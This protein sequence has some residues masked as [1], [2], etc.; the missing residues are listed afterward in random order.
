MSAS[1][2]KLTS[3]PDLNQ[4][5][6]GFTHEGL[7]SQAMFRVALNALSHP[8]RVH[9]AA[10]EGGVPQTGHPA[11]AAL[12][13]S[14]LD[15][16]CTLWLSPKLAH[17]DA[18]AWLRFHTGC[19]LVT[20]AGQARF[21]WVALGDEPPALNAWALGS[22]KLPDQSTTCVVEAAE[23]S[24]GVSE[25]AHWALRGPGIQ[26]VTRLDSTSLTT[27]LGA[28]FLSQWAINHASFPRGVDLFLASQQH[29]VGLPRT[30]A[31]QAS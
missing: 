25:A 7:G 11:A 23:L 16:D 10:Y 29:L 24:A 9:A 1:S 20:Q 27:R 19:Q 4:L 14:L 28:E 31:I 26:E 12:L 18:A 8:G 6:A 21:A 17:S 2:S 13:L 3:A 30:T 22:D 5:A 15:N